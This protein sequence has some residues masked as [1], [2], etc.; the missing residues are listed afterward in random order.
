[1]H[2]ARAVTSQW[3]RLF[4]LNPEVPSSNLHVTAVVPLGKTQYPHC[5]VPQRGLEAISPLVAYSQ[6][7]L[8]VAG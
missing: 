8:L 4:T 1:M 3:L 7:A 6:A 2:S 5:L